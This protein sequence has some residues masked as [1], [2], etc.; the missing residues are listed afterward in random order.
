MIVLFPYYIIH[1]R[2]LGFLTLKPEN[3]RLT[4]AYNFVPS[5]SLTCSTVGHLRQS[6][7]ADMHIR[8]ASRVHTTERL[9]AKN[10]DYK[11][12]TILVVSGGNI[13]HPIPAAGTG[14]W[15]QY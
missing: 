10:G 3:K 1:C 5:K 7:M 2:K 14:K 11:Y 6:L 4:Q 8:Q 12:N 13:Y 9:S 15:G